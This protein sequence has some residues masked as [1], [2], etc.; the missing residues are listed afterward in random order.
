[1]ARYL[2]CL[3]SICCLSLASM[4]V[5]ADALDCNGCI[6][7]GDIGKK[8]VTKKRL[9]K[10][11]VNSRRVKNNS[12]KGKDIKDGTLGGADLADGAVTAAKL[13][14]A[15]LADLPSQICPAGAPTR[16]ADNG[17]GTICDHQ[18]GLMWEKKDGEGGGA[19]PS[20]PHDVDNTY[21]WTSTSPA[22]N[23]TAITVFLVLLNTA[24]D[25]PSMVGFAGYTDWRLSTSGGFAAVFSASTESSWD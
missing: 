10:N 21:T 4:G 12:L 3:I 24:T 23:G 6:D 19:D 8:Q 16:F 14:P 17:D 1:M 22:P 18:T 7:T 5:H 25:D 15:V 9:A 20:N 2:F 13:E 11:A